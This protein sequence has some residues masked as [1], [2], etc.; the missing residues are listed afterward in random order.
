MG[1]VPVRLLGVIA[2]LI[3]CPR[4]EVHAQSSPSLSATNYYLTTNYIVTVVVSSPCPPCVSN[5]LAGPVNLTALALSPT[6]ILLRWRNQSRDQQNIQ[7]YRRSGL[8][9]DRWWLVAD[10]AGNVSNVEVTAPPNTLCQFYAV[11]VAPDSLVS[12]M[13]SNHPPSNMA[14]G[15]I[16]RQ[17]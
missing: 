9:A 6:N 5:D 12:V 2:M 3:I 16:A 10:V 1:T 8:G 11:S 17:K 13:P 7:I 14:T 4:F 15:I